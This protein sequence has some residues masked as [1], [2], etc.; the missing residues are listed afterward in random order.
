[1]TQIAVPER[2]VTLA[3]IGAPHGVKGEVR[4]K[5][6]AAD[7]MA[8][9]AYR[10]LSTKDG[11]SFEI[12][13]LRPGKGV[14]IAKFRGVEDRDAAEALKGLS[15]GVDRDALPAPDTDEFYYADL[16]G[17]SAFD[18]AGASLG[19]VVAVENYGAGD[20]LEIARAG[21]PALLLPFTK[22]VVPDI[23]IARGRIVVVPPEET[24]AK[25]ED[26]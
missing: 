18:A 23:D 24:E 20:I 9:G 19:T 7:P 12:E 1:V 13:R 8:L 22:T 16:I 5:S 21:A 3:T 26:T 10:P 17:L 2:F 15:L 11:R 6:F 4:V 14:L 25:E